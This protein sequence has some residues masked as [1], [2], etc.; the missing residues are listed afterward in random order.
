MDEFHF[1]ADPDR[2]WAWQVPLIELPRAQFLLMSATLG[3]V[4]RFEQD[5]TRRTGR[6]TAVV[7][8]AERPVPLL[9]SYVL[10]P[11]HETLEE[12]LATR[13]AP[14]YV[15]HFTQAAAIEQA[16]AL[17]SINVCTRAEK[18]AIAELIGNFRF[19][20]GF[21]KTLSRLVRH[22]IG[23]HHAGH[24]AQVPA[25]G[26]DPGPGR[27]AEGHLRHRHPRRRHQRADPHRAVH[28]AVQVRRDQDPAAAGPRVP[29]DRRAGRPGRVRHHRATW[30]CRRPST[31]SRT[32]GRWPRPATTRRSGA[33]WCARSRPRASSPGASPRSSGWSPPSPSR[34]SPA[35][36]SAT[37]CCS[38]VIG[39]PGDAFAA[40]RHLLTDNHEDPAAQRR[41]IRRAF[42]IYRALLAGGVVERLA[43][44][45]EQGRRWRLTVDLQDDFA[46]NQPLSPL[47]LA[48]IELL[49]RESPSYPLDVLSVIEATLDD[50]RQVLSA[51]LFKARGEA[52]AQMKADGIEYEER[53]ELLESVT[54]P[55]PL[56]DLL[57][58]AFD[59]YRQGH[60]WVADHELAP[61]SVVRDMYERAMT[62]TE[63]VGF[64]GL[65]R[66]RGPG[67][68]LPGRRLPGAAAD[69]PG[70]GQDRG[71]HRPHRVARRAG[72][73]GRL[74]PDRRVGAAA[75]PGRRTVRAARRAAA[76]GDRQPAGVPGA[77]AQRAVP[78]GRAGRAAPVRGPGRAGRRDRAGTPT[79]GPR[80]WS[81]TSTS[82][83]TSAPAPTRAAPPC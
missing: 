62:F 26:G 51:Q 82:T 36:R 21:G 57:E 27:P 72:P 61:K 41:H 44:P 78:P 2:G 60:P 1:Y 52:V 20:A 76:A 28:R 77:G 8:S 75:R 50:P 54:Y 22:G 68:A 31:W 24:A 30:W 63:Y 83:T 13:Q 37:R 55:K 29:P 65:S 16:Q 17:M 12:L 70:G 56:A 71:A 79:P 40:M 4:S 46:L 64:Y 38:N 59:I 5:L 19:T 42:A 25:A 14:V 48:A 18:D 45:D 69:R 73:P 39:R 10:T 49:D 67:A 15:V 6:P 80:R 43:E 47:A 74:Q 11:L 32:S 81:R 34:C 58:A 66:V 9:F 35:S 7:H 23:V 3:D 53:M 33:R